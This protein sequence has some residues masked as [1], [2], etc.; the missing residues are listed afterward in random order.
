MDRHDLSFITDI[1]VGAWIARELRGNPGSVTGMVPDRFD[2]YVRILHPA[3]TCD[4]TH[5]TWAEVAATLGETMHACRQWHVLVGSSDPDTFEDSRWNGM[6]PERGDLQREVLQSLCGVLGRH[7]SESEHCFFGLWDGWTWTTLRSEPKDETVP[8]VSHGSLRSFDQVKVPRLELPGRQYV[9][10][11]GPVSAATEIREPDDR[12]GSRLAPS[13]PNL[14]WPADCAW[15]LA[16]D[17]DIDSTLVG[18]ST[19]LIEAII[20]ADEIEAWQVGR[21]DSLAADADN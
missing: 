12:S 2:S 14:M 20:E 5:V 3:E 1:S 18:G 19:K 8:G 13:S 10:V 15:F 21:R 6:P 7:T 9:L 17:I 16:S 4:G 11:T